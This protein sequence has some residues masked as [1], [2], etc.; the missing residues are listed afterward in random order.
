MIHIE[1]AYA[2]YFA[3]ERSV[4]DFLAI[5]GRTAKEVKNRR[6]MQFRRHDKSFFIKRHTGVGWGEIVKNLLQFKLPVLGAESEWR[7]IQRLQEIGIRTVT[8]V[9]FGMD[10]GGA[11]NRS[12]F[13]ITEDLGETISLEALTSGWR[14]KPPSLAFRRALIAE[15]A[16]ISRAIHRNGVNHRDFYLC[17]FLAQPAT[18]ATAQFHGEPAHTV[19]LIDLHR[20]Q[21]RHQT[22]ARWV[23][24][25][26]VGLYFSSLDIGLTERDLWQFVRAYLGS[27]WR[28]QLRADARFWRVVREDA[29][30]MY[31]RIHG[32]RP[33]AT[34]VS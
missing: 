8:P 24:K 29:V 25:D 15:I 10:D 18:L 2:S 6:T 12:S 19:Y 14:V 17:H 21:V 31:A 33:D 4:A 23:L 34:Q 27:D 5:A 30:R 13:L 26:L 11:A 16:I 28:A 32:R 20:V 9:A 1:P 3:T 7:A 22:P